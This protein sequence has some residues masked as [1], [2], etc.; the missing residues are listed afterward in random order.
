MH[1]R[2]TVGFNEKAGG[3]PRN[4]EIRPLVTVALRRF[5]AEMHPDRLGLCDCRQGFEALVAAHAPARHIC[6]RMYE[7]VIAGLDPAILGR[8]ATDARVKPG[9]DVVLILPQRR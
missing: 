9:H 2:N 7:I 8:L 5:S 4:W 6:H 1:G 3:I